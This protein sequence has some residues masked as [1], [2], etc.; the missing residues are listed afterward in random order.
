MNAAD[1]ANRLHALAYSSLIGNN[2]A[3]RDLLIQAHHVIQSLLEQRKSCDMTA[4]REQIDSRRSLLR[5]NLVMAA[6]MFGKGGMKP[7][8]EDLDFLD[9]VEAAIGGGDE[10]RS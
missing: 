5:Y 8:Q 4:L 3:E 1:I 6:Q 7:F 2:F 9:L 10:H